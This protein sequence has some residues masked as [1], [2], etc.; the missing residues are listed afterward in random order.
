[1]ATAEVGADVELPDA[2][3]EAYR[4]DEWLFPKRRM[5]GISTREDA[6][7]I[8]SGG[9]VPTVGK[10]PHTLAVMHMEGRPGA[11]PAHNGQIQ[12]AQR[13]P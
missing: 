1:M 9:D 12:P 4:T 13:L 10:R 5:V 7:R 8:L 6:E 2:A 3:R 11:T